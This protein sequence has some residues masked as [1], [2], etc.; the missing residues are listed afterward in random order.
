[1][2]FK[3]FPK[4]VLPCEGGTNSVGITGSAVIDR[5]HNRVHFA[6]VD[7]FVHALD[8]ATGQEAAGWPVRFTS[9]PGHD[10]VWSALTIMN[11]RL[12]VPTATRCEGAIGPFTGNVF[13]IDIDAARLVNTF[14][15]TPAGS[16]RGGGIWG[17]GGVSVDPVDGDVYAATGNAING[18]ESFGYSDQIVR[19]TKD[20]VP[21]AAAQASGSRLRRRLR[22]HPR[23][24][25]A[26]W[27]SSAARRG[28]QGRD[29]L[30]VPP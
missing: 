18:D 23:S 29:A 25:P 4:V 7:G 30:P 3:P 10:F 27:L 2:W 16:G 21:V 15:I 1:M 19:L 22:V 17:W 24:L 20:L 11:R 26:E 28:T 13:G 8:L 9:D 5:V 14:W 12:Y 6:T